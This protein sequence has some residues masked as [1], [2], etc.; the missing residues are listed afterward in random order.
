[1]GRKR[2][3]MQEWV[4][5]YEDLAI[6]EHKKKRFDDDL[7]L[8]LINENNN[9]SI[10][11]QGQV[12]DESIEE[13]SIL[14][15]KY[16]NTEF[17]YQNSHISSRIPEHIACNSHKENKLKAKKREENNKQLTIAQTF[18][19]K[20]KR[21]EI[22]NSVIH[23][24]VRAN[25]YDCIPLYKAELFSGK[26][27]KKY[28][29]CAKT[30]PKK[31]QLYA[32]YLPEVFDSDINWIKDKLISKKLSL[33]IDETSDLLGRPTVNTLVSLYDDSKN[34]KLVLLLDSAIVKANNSS[35][36]I[37]VLENV[38]NQYNKEWSDIIAFCSD[39]A[40]DMRSAFNSIKTSKPHL[41]HI[42]DISHLINVSI[43][44]SLK[45]NSFTDLRKLV[46]KFGA[47]FNYANNLYL[48][49][50]DIC[51]NNNIECKKPPTVA[52]QRWF[53]FFES[54]LVVQDLWSSLMELIDR[55]DV[56]SS[57]VRKIKEVLG[58]SEN[59][60]LLFIKLNFIIDF[61]KPIHII[62]KELEKAEPITHK[63]YE[64][65]NVRVIQSASGDIN[66]KFS[67]KTKLLLSIIP[68]MYAK[69][70]K[71]DLMEFRQTFLNKW[72]AT[73]LRNLNDEVFGDDGFFKKAIIFDPFMKNIEN[74]TFDYYKPLFESID[75]SQQWNDL[76]S[77]FNQYL[78][79]ESPKNPNIKILD[80]W[81][82]MRTTFPNLYENAKNIL[83][84]SCGSIDA[85][86]SF[87]KF[88]NVQS[89]QRCNLTPKSLKMYAIMHFNGDIQG[90][91]DDY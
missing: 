45:L 77:E 6:I 35:E 47:I 54:A 87:S 76:E 34:K 16:C 88:R 40:S 57:K 8:V 64:L 33:I 29:P 63:M 7:E 24:Y 25:C 38:L 48:I 27:I 90:V 19:R 39:S 21:E 18:S 66:S 17:D 83:S 52:E 59:R 23:D 15:C 75:A 5:Q 81:Y 74:Q 41:L 26:F 86:R 84:I 28:I 22:F 12:I 56:N 3:S 67:E 11:V 46:I 32:K 51:D 44:E 73:T 65:C 58:N 78:L 43:N 55:K 62:Q 70:L 53:S 14:I 85:E 30:L 36:M 69:D 9:E 1:M 31:D 61:L 82:N 80:Y 89:S 91:F 79:T 42:A 4:K 20:K 49:F 68:S 50:N 72:N 60:N 10:V 13:N 2:K 37:K 71:L